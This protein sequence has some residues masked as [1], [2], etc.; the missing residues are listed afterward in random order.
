MTYHQ[1]RAD[2]STGHR[3]EP[4]REQRTTLQ[5][6][7]HHEQASKSRSDKPTSRTSHHPSVSTLKSSHA[8]PSSGV[9]RGDDS[10]AGESTTAGSVM[11]GS[12]KKISGPLNAQPILPGQAFGSK[13]AE[14]SDRDRKAKSGRFWSNF[15]KSELISSRDI[16]KGGT[17]LVVLFAGSN[18]ASGS[19]RPAPPS[20]LSPANGQPGRV[21][22]SVPLDH[23]LAVAQIANLPAI[24]FRCI[25]YLEAKKA[26]EEEGIYRLN[27][28][29]AVIKSLKDR[30]NHGTLLTIDANSS[31]H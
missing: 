14:A 5:P 7:S 31:C 1:P 12:S 23:A 15:G 26:A 29:S 21:V 13:A 4:S 27:G 3:A 6:S 2:S 24:V 10:S 22:F 8:S 17:N 18:N 25:E 9:D 20:A 28:S 30:F 19:D 11:S 16:F